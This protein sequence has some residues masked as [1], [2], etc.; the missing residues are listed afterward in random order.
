MLDF[1][2]EAKVFIMQREDLWMIVDDIYKLTLLFTC[3]FNSSP[4][5]SLKGRQST[6]ALKSKFLDST[7]GLGPK[8]GFLLEVGGSISGVLVSTCSDLTLLELGLQ[9]K[10]ISDVISLSLHVSL[11]SILQ[12]D[13]Y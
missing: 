3:H 8:D 2:A 1:I 6:S 4:M 7:S 13:L 11:C 5:F 9:V 10:K 12:P